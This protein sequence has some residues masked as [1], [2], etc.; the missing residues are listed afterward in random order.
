[1][2]QTRSTHFLCFSMGLFS[3]CV[4]WQ[5]IPTFAFVISTPANL[6]CF[7]LCYH[8]TKSKSM[9]RG[10]F[11]C[12][13]CSTYPIH[14]QKKWRG[15]CISC[16]LISVSS[17]VLGIFWVIQVLSMIRISG[18]RISLFAFRGPQFDQHS[19]AH[20]AVRSLNVDPRV[21]EGNNIC[22]GTSKINLFRD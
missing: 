2:H 18:T 10:Q 1:M 14:T 8:R 12:V 3:N 5:V 13:P 7:S 9:D 22:V 16:E 20:R 21:N 19:T 4:H 11:H 15:N 17:P 6:S